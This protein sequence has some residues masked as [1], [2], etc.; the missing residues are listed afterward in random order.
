MPIPLCFSTSG[1]YKREGGGDKITSPYLAKLFCLAAF[2][3]VDDT[4]P[5]H[6][7]ETPETE[8]ERLI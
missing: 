8:E 5:L 1:A 2:M 7:V 3:Y 6:S 4:D